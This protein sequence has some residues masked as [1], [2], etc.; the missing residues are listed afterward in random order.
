L[1]CGARNRV[2]I[3]VVQHAACE[4]VAAAMH[5]RGARVQ[6]CLLMCCFQPFTYACL[7]YVGTTSCWFR[8]PAW[9]TE[10]TS[11]IYIYSHYMYI[12]IHTHTYIHT[13]DVCAYYNYMYVYITCPTSLPEATSG[14][15]VPRSSAAGPRTTNLFFARNTTPAACVRVARES[16][17]CA[18]QD[19]LESPQSSGSPQ[20]ELQIVSEVKR[21]GFSRWGFSGLSG[22]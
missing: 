8:Y 9:C 19:E 3:H 2:R 20:S 1:Q 22:L 5:M 12:Y 16:T 17:W 15:S 11:Y 10:I 7:P 6:M 13:Y 4:A 18:F 14:R 21:W